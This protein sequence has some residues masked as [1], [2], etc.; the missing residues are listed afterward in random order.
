MFVNKGSTM[1]LTCIVHHSPEPPPAIYWTHN[2]EVR[3][4]EDLPVS[5]SPHG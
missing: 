2:E 4:D 3:I 5:P 1:N